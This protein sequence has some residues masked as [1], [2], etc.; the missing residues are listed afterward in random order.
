MY[1]IEKKDYGYKP[2]FSDTI[3][4]QEI[5]DWVEDAKKAFTNYQGAFGVLVDIRELTPLE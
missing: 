1:R 4:K 5:A 2:V 3:D